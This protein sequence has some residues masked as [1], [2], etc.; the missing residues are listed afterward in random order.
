MS[1]LSWLDVSNNGLVGTVL[2]Y[3][4]AFTNLVH[5]DVSTNSL[6]ETFPA[7]LPNYLT[8]VSGLSHDIST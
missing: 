1:K 6:T 3:V 2:N 7:S 8:C 5:L 4:T